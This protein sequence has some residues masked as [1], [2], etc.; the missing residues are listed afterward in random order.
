MYV[1]RLDFDAPITVVTTALTA[2]ETRTKGQYHFVSSKLYRYIGPTTT[3]A[4]AA[5]VDQYVEITN[6]TSGTTLPATNLFVG[7]IFLNTTTANSETVNIV[8]GETLAWFSLGVSDVIKDSFNKLPYNISENTSGEYV[9]QTTMEQVLTADAVEFD[10]D[11]RFANLLP[12]TYNYSVKK[13]L[14]DGTVDVWND[15][16]TVSAAAASVLS[17]GLFGTTPASTAPGV[18][19]ATK[20]D[21]GT[22]ASAKLGTYSYEFTFG[23]LTKKVSVNVEE[24][25]MIKINSVNAFVSATNNQN[26]PLFAGKHYMLQNLGAGTYIMSMTGELA[27]LTEDQYYTIKLATETA[28]KLTFATDDLY[29]TPTAG[30]TVTA[31]KSLNGAS[32]V[33]LGSVTTATTTAIDTLT[34]ELN[35]FNKVPASVATNTGVITYINVPVGVTQVV[36]I[37]AIP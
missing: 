10:F 21:V 29:G 1:S 6:F 32:K 8:T 4:A 23:T 19:F 18:T 7:Q 28:T 13:T 12:G 35:F 27:G 16:A 5:T 30:T 34:Y 3:Q 2:S 24:M 14:P 31:E 25:P 36:S 20:W 17:V 37:K 15:T 33:A 9:I 22:V 26:L 11:V